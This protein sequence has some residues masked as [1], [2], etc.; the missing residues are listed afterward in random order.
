MT[1]LPDNLFGAYGEWPPESISKEE[2]DLLRTARVVME[3]PEVHGTNYGLWS[4][5]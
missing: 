3:K 1:N 5:K 2:I 4:Q